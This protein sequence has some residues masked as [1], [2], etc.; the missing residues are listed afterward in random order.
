MMKPDSAPDLFWWLNNLSLFIWIQHGSQTLIFIKSDFHFT[1][2]GAAS[3]DKDESDYLHLDYDL[4]T[5]ESVLDYLARHPDS[6]Q[7]GTE[8]HERF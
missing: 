6:P 1:V 2:W 5:G 7:K 8:T 4:D 3:L